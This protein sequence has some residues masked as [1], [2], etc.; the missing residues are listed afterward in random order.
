MIRDGG[1]SGTDGRHSALLPVLTLNHKRLHQVSKLGPNDATR[2]NGS[3]ADVKS[4]IHSGT[5]MKSTANWR[6]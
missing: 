5:D 2:D 4:D 1:Q 3:S 6:Q